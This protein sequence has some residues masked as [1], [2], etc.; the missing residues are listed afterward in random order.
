[1]KNNTKKQLVIL[2]LMLTFGV[3]SS[4]SAECVRPVASGY[5]KIGCLQDGLASVLKDGKYGFIDKDG[6]VVIRPQYDFVSGFKEGLSH[7]KKGSKKGY[8][9]TQGKEVIPFEYDFAN[10]FENGI[11]KVS[12]DDKWFYIDKTGK[13]VKDVGK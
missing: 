7:A 6:A 3:I 11:A 9:D 5:K 12:K 1:M 13:F 8:I 2:G 10:D 4:V